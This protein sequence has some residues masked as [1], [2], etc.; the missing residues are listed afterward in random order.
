M[1]LPEGAEWL[2][3]LDRTAPADWAKIQRAFENATVFT[4]PARHEP[5]GLVVLEAMYAALPVV[6]TRIGALKEMVE[7]LSI[8][9]IL[10]GRA[11]AP[12]G[13]SR[14]RPLRYRR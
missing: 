4:L 1:Q 14:Y 11:A 12:I 13:W 7:E 5:F 10:N 2:G 3:F 9:H 8:T 6:A